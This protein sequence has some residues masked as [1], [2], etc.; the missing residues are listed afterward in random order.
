MR[1][2]VWMVVWLW[3]CLTPTGPAVGQNQNDIVNIFGSIVR[4]GVAMAAQ[5][6]WEKLPPTDIACI[7][8]KLRERSSSINL[9]IQQGIGPSDSRLFDVRAACRNQVI[10]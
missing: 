6:A 3:G 5:S 7:D 10:T 1:C 2:W 8:H 4:S 9:I